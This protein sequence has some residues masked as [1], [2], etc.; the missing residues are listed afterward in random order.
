V[1]GGVKYYLS[2]ALYFDIR[3]QYGLA[4]MTNN[5][6]DLNNQ[7]LDAQ[8]NYIYNKDRDRNYTIQASVGFGF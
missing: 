2:R 4:D 3:L 7:K 5:N 8:N 1:I 6:A